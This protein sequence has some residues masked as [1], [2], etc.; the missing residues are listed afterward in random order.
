MLKF[1]PSFFEFTWFVEATYSRTKQ[2]R[3]QSKTVTGQIERW[4]DRTVIFSVHILFF[5]VSFNL[6]FIAFNNHLWKIKELFCFPRSN[7]RNH[8]KAGD[9]QRAHGQARSSANGI[10]AVATSIEIRIRKNKRILRKI[11]RFTTYQTKHKV[12]Y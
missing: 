11:T 4:R 6:L 1:I 12:T 5:L 10:R 8:R 7:S 9:W 2:Q 3:K